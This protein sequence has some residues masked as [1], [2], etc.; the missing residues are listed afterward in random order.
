MRGREYDRFEAVP[1]LKLDGQLSL[2]ENTAD[3]GGLRI[4]YRALQD[5]QARQAPEQQPT[6]IDGYSEDQRFFLGYAQAWCETRTEAYQRVRGK[7]DPH[8]PGEFRF[9][10][11]VQNFEPFVKASGCNVGQ[12]MM[13]ANSCYVW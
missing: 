9:N 5:V 3:N 11:T 1:G 2:G 12:S 4:A 13:P 7:T 8:L 10:G 6:I